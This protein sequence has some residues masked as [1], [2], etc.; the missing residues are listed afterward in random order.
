[1]PNDP[2]TQRYMI[3]AAAILL[4]TAAG[5]GYVLTMK[6]PPPAD[7]DAVDDVLNNAVITA[8][9][10]SHKAADPQTASQTANQTAGQTN[11][12]TAAQLVAQ[13][14]Q[15][16]AADPPTGP[17]RED[18]VMANPGPDT[19]PTPTEAPPKAVDEEPTGSLDREVI[20][21]GIQSMR[22]IVEKC[23]NE[24]LKDFPDAEGR[25]TLA[26]TI[27]AE[28]DEGRVEL[29]ELDTEKTT[30]IDTML[31]DCMLEAVGELR[32]PAPEGNGKVNVKYPFNFAKAETP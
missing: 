11:G 5:M 21:D 20:R 2:S 17:P 3:A 25:V 22:P 9:T 24:T 31:H 27:S 23:Y 30:L 14:A 8:V 6:S 16:I 29:S 4:L 7:H 19:V 18:A 28:D 12:E 15:Q 10:E 1:M 13:T 32:F 26:F